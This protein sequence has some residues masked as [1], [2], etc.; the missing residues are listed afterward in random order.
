MKVS[1]LVSILSIFIL[2][3]L[4]VYSQDGPNG[5]RI[6]VIAEFVEI[7]GTGEFPNYPKNDIYYNHI[8]ILKYDVIKV[9]EGTYDKETLM[10]GQY[11]PTFPRN[12]IKDKMDK[13]VDG[14]LEKFVPGETHKIVLDAPISKYWDRDDAVFDDYFDDEEGDRYF[15]LQTDLVKK[16]K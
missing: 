3:P 15:A 10:V 6:V 13:Y 2:A 7:P 5:D 9:L 1:Q 14:D 8:R 11:M 16:Q 12:K 4:T